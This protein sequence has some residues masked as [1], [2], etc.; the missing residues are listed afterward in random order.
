MEPYMTTPMKSFNSTDLK[1]RTGEVKHSAL[2][3]PIAITDHERTTHVLMSYDQFK[4]LVSRSDVEAISSKDLTED[5]LKL[6]SD[7]T[8]LD[9]LPDY[10]DEM[11]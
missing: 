11:E 3:Q 7:S 9:E 2:T 10:D 1:Q 4:E 8:M 5:Q 6:I